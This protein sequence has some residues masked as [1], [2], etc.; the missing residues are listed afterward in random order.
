MQ[1][2]M[3]YQYRDEIP[4]NTGGAQVLQ[5][6]VMN[7]FPLE[8]AAF[9]PAVL[10]LAVVKCTVNAS[11]KIRID[12]FHMFAVVFSWFFVNCKR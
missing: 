6:N 11:S 1:Y 12:S 9:V 8:F 3:Q 7:Q 10:C 5:K 2:Q 4:G